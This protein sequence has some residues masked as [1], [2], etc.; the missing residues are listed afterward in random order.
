MVIFQGVMFSSNVLQENNDDMIIMPGIAPHEA[1]TNE[2][3]SIN[4]QP[5]VT[6]DDVF[7]NT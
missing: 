3:P 5:M 2:E 4:M 7:R 1:V 6:D